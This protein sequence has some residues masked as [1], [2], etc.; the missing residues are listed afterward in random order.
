L[1]NFKYS[2]SDSLLRK[3]FSNFNPS[4]VLLKRVLSP[5]KRVFLSINLI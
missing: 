3:K 5:I 2:S 4:L 1:K